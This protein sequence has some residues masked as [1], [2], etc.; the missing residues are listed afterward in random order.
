MQRILHLAPGVNRITNVIALQGKGSWLTDIQG[1]SYLDMTSGIGALSTG[2]CHPTVTDKV[3]AQLDTLVHAQQN[4]VET[5]LPQIELVNKMR[6]VLP[7]DMDT[8]FFTNSGSEAVENAIK[9]ARKATGKTNII[10]FM[11]GFH[12][13]TLGCM[14][15]TTS[16]SSSREGYQPLLPGIFHTDYPYEGT[17]ER[18]KKQLDTLLTRA[19]SPNETAAVILE[20]ILGEGGLYQ[21][22]GEFMRYLR[23]VCN[24]HNIAYVSDEVQTGVGRTGK[25]W[26]YQHFDNVEP[27]IITFGK[28]IAS[29]FTLAGVVSNSKNFANIQCNGLGGT[30][31][32]SVIATVAANSTIDILKNNNLV[33]LS[34]EKGEYLKAAISQLSHPKILDVRQYGLM[35]AIELDL[36]YEPFKKLLSSAPEHNLLLLS[37]GLQATVRLLPPLTISYEEIDFFVENFRELLNSC[38]E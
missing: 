20:P 19:T 35:I 25:W 24:K 27:D 17:A 2:H 3:K 29:G 31:N 33:A 13:R 14:S 9:I 5:H 7:K 36:E 23:Q 10:T 22:D 32:G 37:T 21:A 16:K 34:N 26:G 18:T 30:Y 11:G 38:Q 15:L 1:H 12:G 4:C 6:T 8:F 28:G